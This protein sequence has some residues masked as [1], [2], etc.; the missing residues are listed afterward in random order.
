MR[1]LDANDE[2]IHEQLLT[3]NVLASLPMLNS[4]YAPD[5][6]KIYNPYIVGENKSGNSYSISF[7]PSSVGKE[8]FQQNALE[9]YKQ[10]LKAKFF[11]V[12]TQRSNST[13]DYFVKIVAGVTYSVRI[14]YSRES[15]NIITITFD[16]R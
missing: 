3:I 4:Y 6:V 10:L 8:N 1:S 13:N 7:Q 5:F 14:D 12:D 9:S 16:A 15:E 11:R 2:I